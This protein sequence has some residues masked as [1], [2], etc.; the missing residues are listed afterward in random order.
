MAVESAA[1][2]DAIKAA[3]LVASLVAETAESMVGMLGWKMVE[4]SAVN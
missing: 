1:G 3:Q 4:Y 2:L